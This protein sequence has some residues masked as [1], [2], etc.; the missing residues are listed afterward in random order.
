[1]ISCMLIEMDSVA[2]QPLF[3]STDFFNGLIK[4]LLRFHK[5]HTLTAQLEF[6]ST[7]VELLRE[8]QLTASRKVS[9][10]QFLKN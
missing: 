9:V 5:K 6:L 7:T 3:A 8:Y 4:K 10:T 2:R 1:M